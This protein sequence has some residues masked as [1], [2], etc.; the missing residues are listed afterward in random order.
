MN[1]A[2]VD[3]VVDTVELRAARLRLCGDVVVH[4]CEADCRCIV[5]SIL[6]RGT[7]EDQLGLPPFDLA[8]VP[9]NVPSEIR[10]SGQPRVSIQAFATAT[11]AS[12]SPR[13]SIQAA[14]PG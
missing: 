9:L 6:T 4:A 10:A 5:S 13:V 7:G 11:R 1:T 14:G 8:I 3:V 12:A 2:D